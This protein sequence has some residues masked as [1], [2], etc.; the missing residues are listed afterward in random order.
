MI[1]SRLQ[2]TPSTIT[3][4]FL[5]HRGRCFENW[6][7][8]KIYNYV[9]VN[10]VH[11]NVFVAC[12][13]DGRIALAAIAW[14]NDAARIEENERLGLPQYDWKG[15]P[16]DGDSILIADVAGDRKL[17]PEILKQVMDCWCHGPWRS[18]SLPN[19][20]QKRIFTYRR[21]RL[22]E[23][24]WKT[25]FRFMSVAAPRECA[26]TGSDVDRSFCGGS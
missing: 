6:S 4:F 24:G 26:L 8:E 3:A 19:I 10:C 5:S 17:M 9:L 20:F 7:A 11:R 25:V 23:L 15:F 22:V 2:P 18:R 12:D 16:K 1:F 21:G 13:G 14:R